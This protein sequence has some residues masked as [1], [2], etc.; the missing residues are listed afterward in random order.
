MAILNFALCTHDWG[1]LFVGQ[2]L[3]SAVVVGANW[4]I[5]GIWCAGGLGALVVMLGEATA[6][7]IAGI[8]DWRSMRCVF[9][10]GRECWLCWAGDGR[11]VAE[12]AEVSQLLGTY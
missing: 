9:E 12:S 2:I 7:T 3:A 10:V 5:L 6:L 8:V 1:H 4:C 11:T